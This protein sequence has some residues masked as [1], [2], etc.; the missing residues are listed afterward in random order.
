M[1]FKPSRKIL[2]AGGAL[3]A[4]ALFG[5]SRFGGQSDAEYATAK[6]S[7]AKLVQTISETGAVRASSELDLNFTNNGKVA[8][9]SVAVGD[10]V[11]KGQSLAELDYSQLAIKQRQAEANLSKILA[12][13]SVQDVAVAEASLRQAE[14]S[15][16]S[17]VTD[18]EKTKK[19]V[20]ENIAQAQKNLYDLESKT[21]D[22]VT[23]FEQAVATA[24]VNLENTRKT[25]EQSLNNRIDSA[26]STADDKLSVARIALDNINKILSDDDARNLFSV[27]DLQY[28]A[29]TEADY[30]SAK[31]LL[32]TASVELSPVKADKAVSS[33]KTLL[34]SVL[35]AVNK[36]SG[37]LGNCYKA[38][39][40]SIT[41]S[42]FT[43]AELDGYK[44]AISAQQS[45][46]S[47]SIAAVQ[48]AKQALDD[49]ELAY[50][51]NISA[52]TNNL[53]QAKVSLNNA[54][55]SARNAFNTARLSGDREISSAQS[56]LDS[57]FKALDVAR[58]QLAK[59]K[60]PAR[61]QDVAL[62]QAD[63]DSAKAQIENSII[64]API[65]GVITKSN[66]LPGEEASPSKPVFSMLGENSLEVEILVSEA[67]VS[68]LKL[69]QPA[70]VTFDAFPSDVIFKGQVY[71]I[72][73]AA[74]I[75]QEVVYYK[76]KVRLT[77][78]A[79]VEAE[80]IKVKPGMTANAIITTAE[81]DNILVIPSRAVVEKA[82]GSK[83]VRVLVDEQVN[84]VPVQVGLKGDEGM[85]EIIA[86]GL[87]EGDLVVTSVKSK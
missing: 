47:L 21:D 44:S 16:S 33:V 71:F 9:I 35:S 24:E 36:T 34:D 3:V 65:D 87:K 80:N 49:A 25:Y 31:E 18:L 78:L 73:P 38:L 75:V 7:R 54:M 43:Q 42:S 5:V 53:D 83:I 1:T 11:I 48:S 79:E 57:S 60:A 81:K 28:K 86:D 6:V 39:E 41:S 56:R 32:D 22:D 85:V 8:K 52:A 20:S 61:Q 30:D 66:Y 67:D 62:A 40:N 63:L 27:K 55:I 19:S 10:M 2:I 29:A 70:E 58:S 23:N 26:V 50:N 68:K 74:T 46:V 13:A 14:A 4:V 72:E 37:S 15:Y 82:D 59:V 51:T 17:A 84:E 45:T 76:V 12:G 77:N 64:R 69:D